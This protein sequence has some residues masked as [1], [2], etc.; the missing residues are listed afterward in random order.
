MQAP[1]NPTDG[2]AMSDQSHIADIDLASG[3]SAF[4]SRLFSQAIHLL[5]PY[6]QQGDPDAQHRMAIMYQN[7]LG[8]APNPEMAFDWMQKAAEQGHALAQHG[9]GFMYM[10]GD[11]TDKDI[12]KAI[13]WFEKAAEQGLAGSATT[14]A[15]I[16]EQGNGV[17]KDLDKAKEW[18]AKGGFEDYLT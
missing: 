5:S 6:A 3:M 2:T 13:H 9:I 12:P 15:M 10:E 16:Y 14:L 11:C 8:V 7:G 4:E 17:E 1:N 18:Y